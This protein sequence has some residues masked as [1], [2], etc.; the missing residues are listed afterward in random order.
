VLRRWLGLFIFPQKRIHFRPRRHYAGSPAKHILTSLHYRIRLM[1][2]RTTVTLDD[3]IYE[4]ALHLSRTSGQRLGK[5]LSDLVRR[6]IAPV[7]HSKK[8]SSRRF[9]T[10]DVPR[11]APIIPASRIQ[12]FLDEE[13]IL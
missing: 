3:D 12:K 9:P 8:K 6:A 1:S 5:V 13:G 10:F 11:G 4:A 7:Q 2:M